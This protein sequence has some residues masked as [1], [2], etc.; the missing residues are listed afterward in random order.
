[1]IAGNVV[2][3]G[4]AGILAGAGNAAGRRASG[5]QLGAVEALDGGQEGLLSEFLAVV[6]A[7]IA[8]E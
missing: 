2:G 4:R 6:E 5:Q 3:P 8:G 7:A 1:M